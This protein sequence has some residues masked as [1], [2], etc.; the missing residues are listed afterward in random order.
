VVFTNAAGLALRDLGLANREDYFESATNRLLV[1]AYFST[2]GDA[3]ARARAAGDSFVIFYGPEWGYHK[4]W[5]QPNG[6]FADLRV[7]GPR[8]GVDLYNLTDT[9]QT[10]AL[11]ASVVAANGAK[12]VGVAGARIECP[13][14]RRVRLE[15]PPLVLVPGSN[16]VEFV[17]LAG[18]ASRGVLLVETMELVAPP[19]AATPTGSAP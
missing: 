6:S 12:H 10:Q 19:R 15:T 9:V 8:A 16:R 4:P 18:P 2:R 11:V 1:T 13:Q 14:G 7:L 3:V 17:D 5:R